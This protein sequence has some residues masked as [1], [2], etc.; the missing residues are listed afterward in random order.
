MTR[1]MGTRGSTTSTVVSTRYVWHDGTHFHYCNNQLIVDG[2]LHTV[3]T[4]RCAL[5]VRVGSY[6]AQSVVYHRHGK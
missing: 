4:S 1:A 3:L 6:V 5:Q 2:K